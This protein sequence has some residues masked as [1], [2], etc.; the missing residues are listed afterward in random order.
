M[1]DPIAQAENLSKTYSGHVALSEVSFDVR[2]GEILGLLGPNGAGKTTAIRILLGVIGTDT[3]S[4]RLFGSPL[5]ESTKS[6][7]GYL[8][9]ERGLY[10]SD[11]V[12]DVL[13]YLGTLKGMS[14]QEARAQANLWLK[15]LGL[16][17]WSLRKVSDLS[18][19]MQQKVQFIAAVQHKPKLVVLDEPFSGLDP[20][21]AQTLREQ[22]LALR[23]SGVAVILSTHQMEAA[24]AMCDRVLMIDSGE[25]MLYD[26]LEAIKG[27]FG[28]NTLNLDYDGHLPKHLK[29]AKNIQDFGRTAQIELEAGTDPSDVLR[30]LIA[31]V[32]IR[33]FEL[34][35]PSLQQIFMEVARHE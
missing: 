17:E 27:R 10:R 8:P 32:R 11:K 25:V 5:S 18:K 31:H 6:Q 2:P 28:K 14:E 30:E 21:N 34:A 35:Q 1:S 20:L 9:E 3:G 19:G 33:R 12:S 23:E 16:E 7:L 29:G 22:I 4:V 13:T 24:E 26:T 15:R